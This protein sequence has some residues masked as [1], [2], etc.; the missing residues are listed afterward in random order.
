MNLPPNSLRRLIAL[1]QYLVSIQQSGIER[2]SSEKLGYQLGES[3]FTIR[4]DLNYLG[5]TGTKGSGYQV[6]KLLEMLR[7]YLFT[8]EPGTACI[9]GLGK[10]GALLL[11]MHQEIFT[12][13]AELVAGFDININKIE[14]LP[15]PIPLFPLYE[16]EEVAK[17]S[18]IT[19][20]ILTV[21][22]EAVNE[23]VEK[24]VKTGIRCIINYS[25][26]PVNKALAKNM[27]VHNLNLNKEIKYIIAKSKQI[28][29]NYGKSI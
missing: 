2:V 19:I 12:T 16:L 15:G 8:K 9:I 6:E 10:L 5:V 21:N 27:I 1:E 25:N 11:Q 26:V 23:V 4:K 13:P 3:A 14:T 20:A 18:K 7:Q 17:T 22:D 29:F 28:N 24:I